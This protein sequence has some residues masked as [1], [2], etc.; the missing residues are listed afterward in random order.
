MRK[1][2]EVLVLDKQKL[3]AAVITTINNPNDGMNA[4][5]DFGKAAGAPVI[6]V[7]DT[8]TP[9]SWENTDFEYLSIETQK[10]LFGS[11]SDLIPTRH[12]ARK[13]LGYLKARSHE[14]EW[15]Y[16]TDDD[17]VP[18]LSPFENRT[19]NLDAQ[20]FGS[21][22]S[23]LNVYEVFGYTSKQ[24]VP[25]L[26]WPRGFDLRSVKHVT[27][28]LESKL[29]TAPI[30]Q[31]LANGDPDVDAIYRLVLGN[32]VNFNESKPVALAKAQICPTNSQTT[33][34]HASIHQLMYLPSTCTFRL[35]DI[36]RG[37][38]AWRILQDRNETVSFHS[39]IVRQDRNEHDLLKDFG[40]EMELYLHSDNLIS[41]LLKLDLTQLST[42]QQLIACYEVFVDRGVVSE[43]EIEIIRGWNSHF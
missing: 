32:F 25:S 20:I 43:F 18:T 28:K 37:F 5:L 39:P 13:N 6:V 29:V 17:N 23:W 34:W 19:L 41:D 21:E 7:G 4:L 33:W 38:V 14:V 27:T 31:G 15:I 36:L 3:F 26:I 9:G 16:E 2:V 10:D 24:E 11:F 35:T 12:Y 8:K 42:S 30:Q 40:D 22:S 1:S